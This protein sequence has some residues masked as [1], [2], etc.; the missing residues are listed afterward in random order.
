[1]RPLETLARLIHVHV[2]TLH[3]AARDGRLRVTYDT[4]TTFRSLRARATVADADAF[5]HTYFEKATWPTDRP[6]PLIWSQIPADYDDQIR[7][8]R[9]RLGLTQ[10]QFAARVGA[11][12]KA[13]VYQWEARK[14]C[15]SPL[16]WQR[17]REIGA[18]DSCR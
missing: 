8:V 5:L 10:A 13:V 3:A 14:R 12:R 1:L 11:A 6:A 9:R 7:R 2:K 4:R 17:I 15:P 16:F 18:S